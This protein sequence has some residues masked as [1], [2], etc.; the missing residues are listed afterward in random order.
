MPVF[1]DPTI[2]P[3]MDQIQAHCAALL[4]RIGDNVSDFEAALGASRELGEVI[5]N[6]AVRALVFE[7][8]ATKL[9]DGD[10]EYLEAIALVIGNSPL[11]GD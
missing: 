2:R 10:Q 1:D 8:G 7:R 6:L 3:R 5:R 4:E 11:P 9:A